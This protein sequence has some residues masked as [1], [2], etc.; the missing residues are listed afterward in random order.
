MNENGFNK[1]QIPTDDTSHE[2]T[3][4]EQK[5]ILELESL[6]PTGDAIAD[7]ARFMQI[8]YT[9]HK[10][11]PLDLHDSLRGLVVERHFLQTE[12]PDLPAYRTAALNALGRILEH[13]NITARDHHEFDDYWVRQEG[14]PLATMREELE[15]FAPRGNLMEDLIQFLKITSAYHSGSNPQSINSLEGGTFTPHFEL[16]SFINFVDAMK[17]QGPNA[18]AVAE[19]RYL[20]SDLIPLEEEGLDKIC[21]ANGYQNREGFVEKYIQNLEEFTPSGDP[22]VDFKHYYLHLVGYGEGSVR[23]IVTSEQAL[24]K[25]TNRQSTLAWLLGM[26]YTDASHKK[27]IEFVQRVLN[28]YGLQGYSHKEWLERQNE[29]EGLPFEVV[30]MA[31]HTIRPTGDLNYDAYC[32]LNVTGRSQL[33]QR[34]RKKEDPIHL[35]QEVVSEANTPASSSTLQNEVVR[36]TSLRDLENNLIKEIIQKSREHESAHHS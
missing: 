28:H 17:R 1:P 27:E 32:F 11:S 31:L 35:L 7:A 15:Q 14:Q 16:L 20:Y 33:V 34:L 5:E 4:E 18:R 21:G 12:Y 36:P 13:Y 19:E 6:Q 9:D 23:D 29:A 2:L 3:G 24:I 8:I 30:A 25:F 26:G 10:E 22:L